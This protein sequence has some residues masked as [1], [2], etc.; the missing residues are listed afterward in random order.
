MLQSQ[1]SESNRPR[2]GPASCRQVAREIAREISGGGARSK[3]AGQAQ[4]TE[5]TD[6]GLALE[7]R[8]ARLVSAAA[9][10]PMHEPVVGC[11]VS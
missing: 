4:G 7:A 2:T 1:G 3:V 6:R 8:N 11:N 10:G 9:L 5:D